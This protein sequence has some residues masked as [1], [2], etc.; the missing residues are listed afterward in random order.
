MG[1]DGGDESEKRD[2]LDSC[3]SMT[4]KIPATLVDLLLTFHRCCELQWD[5]MGEMRV[6][7]KMTL[8][9]ASELMIFITRKLHIYRSPKRFT[10]AIK[11]CSEWHLC[12]RNCTP[13]A[14]AHSNKEYNLFVEIQILKLRWPGQEGLKT[15]YLTSWVRD[16][17]WKFSVNEMFID[18]LIQLRY[19][20]A[21]LWKLSCQEIQARDTHL[22]VLSCM[23]FH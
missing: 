9:S 20:C 7:N 11:G 21:T 23:S 4:L 1:W 2:D 17:S 19:I 13:T 22:P 18:P 15:A 6:K 12:T 10:G 14:I 5:E 3:W 16:T 8:K